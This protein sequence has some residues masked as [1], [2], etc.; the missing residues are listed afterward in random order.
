LSAS[1]KRK[2]EALK[3]ELRFED[4]AE[5]TESAIVE[6]LVD[7]VKLTDLKRHF[8]KRKTNN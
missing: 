3:S 5:V 8:R 1:A 4:Y 2:L 7:A 6:V